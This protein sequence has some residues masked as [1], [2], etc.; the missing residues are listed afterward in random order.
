M[1]RPILCALTA[2]GALIGANGAGHAQTTAPYAAPPAVEP[3][4][5]PKSANPYGATYI[6][7]VGFRYLAPGGARV[8]GYR[9][10]APRVYGDRRGYRQE[11]CLWL[12]D[13]CF[14]RRR[15]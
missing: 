8:Y 4:A 11:R 15:R 5:P 3:A 9:T 13:D 10:Y 14:W 2:A 6:P 1:R 12:W 7:G